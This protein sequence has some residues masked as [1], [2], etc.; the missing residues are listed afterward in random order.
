VEAGGIAHD[1]LQFGDVRVDIAAH[2]LLRTGKERLIEPKAYA[3]LV[4][5]LSRP[6]QLVAKEELLDLVWGHRQV[7]PGV[8]TRL[9]GQIR[10][11]IGDDAESPRYIQTVHKL[12]YCFIG[13]LYPVGEPAAVLPEA[14]GPASSAAVAAHNAESKDHYTL[15]R[16]YWYE[17][18]PE[19][20][21]TGLA[22]FREALR[23][24][25]ENGEAWCGI[26]DSYLLLNEYAD[27]SF[28]EAVREA[29]GA[30][31]V[32]LGLDPDLAQAYAS[33]GLLELELRH[34]PLAISLLEQASRLDPTLGYARGWHAMALSLDGRLE[35]SEAVLHDALE[36]DPHDVV[37]LTSLS[38]NLI[39]RGRHRSAEQLL[40]GL[41]RDHPG[42]LESYW[43]L[44]WSMAQHGQLAAA[45]EVLEYADAE[46]GN[47]RWTDLLR[48]DVALMCGAHEVAERVM[49][50]LP[51]ESD[52]RLW[53]IY[54]HTLWAGSRFE[55]AID[56]LRRL[57]AGPLGRVHQATLLAHS[58]AASER[59]AEALAMYDSVFRSNP[60]AREPAIRP[61]EMAPGL[62]EQANHIALLDDAHPSRGPMLLALGAQIER[63]RQGGVRLPALD[64]QFAVLAALRGDVEH[65]L[66]CLDRA[67]EE[68]FVDALAFRRD[69]VWQRVA[70]ADLAEREQALQGAVAQDR[71][72]IERPPPAPEAV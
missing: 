56:F 19:D 57:V 36:R 10:H 34:F 63:L 26:A 2:R 61:W 40:G 3:V 39:L 52:F 29:R 8:L 44:A 42:V 70:P 9:I 20:L 69:L 67:L 54:V 33:Q 62:G 46:A 72:L 47:S 16:R 18:S 6:G 12:G 30:I 23:A 28:E 4:H 15:G 5:L 59:D 60:I 58:L 35:E 66:R 50:G 48:A 53:R 1:V 14:T 38:L 55:E 65:S 41:R 49:R 24:D 45:Y 13:Q 11:A 27:V 43:Q 22:H 21:L 68:G 31:G 64:Y 51:V 71:S 17:R 32:A 7:T 25:P 37:L